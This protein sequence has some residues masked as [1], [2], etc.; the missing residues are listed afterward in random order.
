MPGSGSGS[1]SGSSSDN[2]DEPISPSGSADSTPNRNRARFIGFVS[3]SGSA[4]TLSEAFQPAFPHGSPFHVVPFRTTLS[5]LSR[6][7]T[8][9]IVLVDLSGED[10]PLNAM[11]D[12]AEVVES[13][14]IVL[15]IGESRDLSFYRAA[16][17]GMGVKEYLAKPL[18]KAAITRHFLPLL[19]PI[20]QAQA[21]IRRGGR[22]VAVTGVRGGVGTSTI[23]TNLAWSVGHDTHRHAVLL[24][25]DLQCGTT[26]LTLGIPATRGLLTAIESPERV[27][28]ML[29]ERVSQPAGDRLHLLAAQELVEKEINYTPG[30]AAVLTKALRQRYNF[31]IVD[32]GARHLPFAR[33]LLNLAHQ[34]VIVLDPTI[35][36]IRNLERLNN[37][38]TVGSQTPKPILVLNQACRPFGMSQAFM[39]EKLGLKFDVVIPDLPRLIAKSEQYGDMAASVRGPFRTAIMQLAKLLGAD[40][41]LDEKLKV[42]VAA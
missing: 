31:V 16:I 11:M 14:T 22:L 1:A 32:A 10:Q 23:A 6:M 20:T 29:I 4:A 40:P 41:L 3:E 37:L 27:D 5:I 18:T 8:P 19:G 28:H 25:A 7:V 12:L 38:P 24:D 9:E 34:R 33:D 36:A 39:E 42:T 2:D 17:A 35:L 13:G 21:D 30:A 15:M 26:N